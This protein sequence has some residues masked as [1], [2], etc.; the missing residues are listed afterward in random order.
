MKFLVLWGKLNDFIVETRQWSLNSLTARRR[1]CQLCWRRIN[2]PGSL[3][4]ETPLLFQS[5]LANPDCWGFKLPLQMI[6]FAAHPREEITVNCRADFR[7]SLAARRISRALDFILFC[8]HPRSSQLPYNL[9]YSCRDRKLPRFF[10]YL[11]IDRAGKGSG[12][13]MEICACVSLS[14]QVTLCI[15][16]FPEEKTQ[17]NSHGW[18]P[19]IWVQKSLSLKKGGEHPCL[20]QN[21]WNQKEWQKNVLNCENFPCAQK[22]GCQKLSFV[23]H[24]IFLANEVKTWHLFSATKRNLSSMAF[25]P[26]LRKTLIQL[27]ENPEWT[28]IEK[29]ELKHYLF[30]PQ[31]TRLLSQQN[32]VAFDVWCSHPGKHPT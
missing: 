5:C 4:G 7:A 13:S 20:A 17:R 32:S 31:F 1:Q 27:K 24:V 30:D 8:I 23:W 3:L 18:D 14:C 26:N 29:A 25:S 2:R 19:W 9:P 15:W 21:N 6:R 16:K 28:R 22:Y 12:T 11:W 10:F